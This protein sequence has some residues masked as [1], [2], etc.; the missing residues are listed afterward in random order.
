MIEKMKK[1]V[2]LASAEGKQRLLESLRNAGVMH[3]TDMVR[4]SPLSSDYEEK[5]GE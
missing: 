1:V 2:I 5:R 4:K 3:V